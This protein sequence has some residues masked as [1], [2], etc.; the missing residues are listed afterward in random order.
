MTT[1]LFFLM[2]GLATALAMPLLLQFHASGVPGVRAFMLANALT[3]LSLLLY[4]AGSFLPLNA[5]VMVSNA[6]WISALALVYVGVRQ[7]FGLHPQVWRSAALA[8][9]CVVVM[10]AMLYGQDRVAAR[11]VLFSV[12][13]CVGMGA[14][15]CVIFDG[16]R[17]IRT[18]GVAL[19]LLLSILGLAALH[20]LRVLVYGL[21][22]EAPGSMLHPTPWALFFIVGGSVTVPAL[23]LALLLLVQTRMSE[24]MQEALTFDSLTQ[25]YSRRSFMDELQHELR[26]CERNDG[27][28]VVLLLDIDFFK[29]IN[30]R[31][32]HATGGQALRHFARVV[33]R[34]VRASDRFGRLGGEE[35]ALL[36]YDCEPA[37]A[38]VQAQR[39]CD[40]L[41]DAPLHTVDGEIRM[42]VSGGLAA[43]R[44]GDTA[45]GILAR[46][47]VAL[48][49]AK[50]LGRDRVETGGSVG[51]GAAATWDWTAQGGAEAANAAVAASPAGSKATTA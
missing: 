6:A 17:Q 30:D 28:L 18:R 10:T 14:T 8:I 40:A 41:R 25:A 29:A 7:F 20:L 23:F 49:R 24:R 2:W 13:T 1:S 27:R 4:A 22:W 26:R 46:A 16:R 12:I 48:Y 43:Y 51:F 50:E 21:G 9:L 42:T 5:T 44:R 31:H 39:V 3:V 32:G 47:D 36:M 45:D 11:I 34:A 35:F 19:Y 37:S 15:A 33:Q 38:L